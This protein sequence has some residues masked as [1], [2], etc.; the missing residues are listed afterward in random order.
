[1]GD[2]QETLLEF[3][4]GKMKMEG[5]TVRPDTRKGVV[6]ITRSDDG[7]RHV[8]WADRTSNVIEEDLIVFPEESVFEKVPQSSGRVFILK[9]KHDN[10]KLIFWMQEPKA[11]KDD[12]IVADVNRILNHAEDDSDAEVSAP[13]QF[14]E[15][16][17]A[18]RASEE[19]GA[20]VSSGVGSSGVEA[21]G[22][23]RPVSPAGA[24][25]EG[26]HTGGAVKL[27]DLQSI[28]SGLGSL[29]V[30][31]GARHERDTGPTLLDVL[32]PER[33]LPLLNNP[34]I[35]ERL[36]PHL[37][38]SLRTPQEMRELV[39]SPQFQQQ[40]ETFSSALQS[41]QMD[42]S[43]FGI[44]PSKYGYSVTAFLQAI[45][46]QAK[47]VQSKEAGTSSSGTAK[48][49]DESESSRRDKDKKPDKMDE[50]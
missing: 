20:E 12:Q 29:P 14:E 21:S 17:G 16:S 9:F 39:Q 6:R 10:R 11:D 44:D 23:G 31:P 35:Q 36:A 43:Q 30:P 8:S 46:D 45:E 19:L 25:G 27:S 2:S 34:T 47:D 37:P 5:S 42:L 26:I 32:R 13:G 38:E 7:L 48:A 4:A 18:F 49:G 3:R 1:M 50:S 33:I 41:G 28:L 40:V 15:L 22:T 24:P